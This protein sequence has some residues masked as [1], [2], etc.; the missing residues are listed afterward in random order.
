MEQDLN[1]LLF[2]KLVKRENDREMPLFRFQSELAKVIIED[3]NV[4]EGKTIE[5]I[6]PYLSQTLKKSDDQYQKPM[7]EDM[8]QA[9]IEAIKIR[10]HK[11][12]PL[13]ED[14]QVEFD[15]AYNLLKTIGYKGKG[16]SDQDEYVELKKWQKNSNRTVIFNSEPSEAKWDLEEN[17]V[18]IRDLVESMIDNLFKN[19]EETREVIKD[20]IINS[21]KSE[22]NYLPELKFQNRNEE[23]YYRF[24]VP[25]FTVAKEVWSG[26]LKFLIKFEFKESLDIDYSMKISYAEKLL[27]FFH[28]YKTDEEN[29]I[30]HNFLRVYKVDGYLTTIPIVY[31]ECSEGISTL[32]DG[33]KEHEKLFTFVIS[34][35]GLRYSVGKMSGDELNFWKEHIYYPL[36]LSD[37]PKFNVEEVTLNKVISHIQRTLKKD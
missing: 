15:K 14:V 30:P 18:E 25:S 29:S 1:F 37:S 8:K 5:G 36:H 33:T 13:Y 6:R 10:L 34:D 20:Q 24:Y 32:D 9:I 4:Y 7:S 19:F 22:T 2:K 3:T 27:K 31:Y 35:G 11:S 17:G 28:R 21:S 26:L 16:V 23:Y 12:D